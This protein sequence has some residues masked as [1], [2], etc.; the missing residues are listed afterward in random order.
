MQP[1]KNYYPFIP[2][3]LF[4]VTFMLVDGKFELV[5]GVLLGV[6]FL[7]LIVSPELRKKNDERKAQTQE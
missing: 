3:I 4:A 7:A 1:K 6:F 2:L 5:V